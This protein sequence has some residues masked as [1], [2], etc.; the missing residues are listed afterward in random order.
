MKQ[1]RCRRCGVPLT[2]RQVYERK[3]KKC[4]EDEVLGEP[5]PA[6]APPRQGSPSKVDPRFHQADTVEAA[7]LPVADAENA[8][9]NEVTPIPVAEEHASH[10]NS[11]PAVAQPREEILDAIPVNDEED[12]IR[13]KEAPRDNGLSASVEEEPPL[14]ERPVPAVEVEL[15][16]IELAAA[17][18]R[19]TPE[20]EPQEPIAGLP[21]SPRQAPIGI[22]AADRIEATLAMILE[23]LRTIRRLL[24]KLSEDRPWNI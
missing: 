24:E 8:P 3:C 1:V 16:K 11:E 17:P 9:K 5:I 2:G 6:A 7:P 13:T 12:A 4:I 21:A 18:E 23:E 15:P 10:G 20:T 19:A 22:P 14:P